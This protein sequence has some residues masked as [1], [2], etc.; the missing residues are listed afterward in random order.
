MKGYHFSEWYT[1]IYLFQREGSRSLVEK[2]DTYEN[3]AHNQ[4]RKKDRRKVAEYERVVC[5]DHRQVHHEICSKWKVGLPDLL[6]IHTDGGYSFAEVK[7]PSRRPHAEQRARSEDA[8][9]DFGTVE[10]AYRGR[11]GPPLAVTISSNR[12]RLRAPCPIRRFLRR[13]RR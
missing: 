7:G 1:A 8:Q 5:D 12:S 9:R 10:G 11:H 6:V 4:K 3:H 2:Y 13:P